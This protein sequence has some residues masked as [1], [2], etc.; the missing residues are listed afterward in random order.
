MPSFDGD[1]QISKYNDGHEEVV[2]CQ[3]CA[4]YD[5]RSFFTVVD[6]SYPEPC[7]ECG[8]RGR[9]LAERSVR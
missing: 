1:D 3:V 6:V 8:D 2:L 9:S 7:E 4:Y 5:P